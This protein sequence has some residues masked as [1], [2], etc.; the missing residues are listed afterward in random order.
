MPHN[1][2]ARRAR[3]HVLLTGTWLM[4]RVLEEVG[5]F[6]P[7]TSR[8][9]FMAAEGEDTRS[10]GSPLKCCALR[11]VSVGSGL[12]RD[13]CAGV[14][15]LSQPNS[16]ESSTAH[17]FGS[18]WA[19][20]RWPLCMSVFFVFETGLIPDWLRTC[21]V[22]KGSTSDPASILPNDPLCLALFL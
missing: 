19:M 11:E 7:W 22:P 5:E 18:Y 13:W 21:H 3:H 17:S 15:V 12:S 14:S 4:D 10:W 1:R 2:R 6:C 9:S 20:L 16:S 8:P